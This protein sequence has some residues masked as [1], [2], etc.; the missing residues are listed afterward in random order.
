MSQL[1]YG[2]MLGGDR[3]VTAEQPVAEQPVN[4]PEQLEAVK[5][6]EQGA[7]RAPIQQGSVWIS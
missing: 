5:V 2:R 7:G 6:K 3:V 4:R 1:L